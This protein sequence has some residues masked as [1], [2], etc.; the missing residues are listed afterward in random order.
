MTHH[1]RHFV[2]ASVI[3]F[4]HG[5]Q[6]AA[7]NRFKA[8]VQVWYRTLQN[9]IRG[10][11]Q[12][13]VLVH[14]CQL[15]RDGVAAAVG[16]VA[17]VLPCGGVIVPGRVLLRTVYL[18]DILFKSVVVH[19]LYALLFAHYCKFKQKMAKKEIYASNI[20]CVL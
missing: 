11:V 20:V 14:A 8:I 15:V 19:N 12:E 2:V 17:A 10:I 4:A 5:M 13:P 18:I 6:D 16:V 1:V 3:K 9:H 7:L